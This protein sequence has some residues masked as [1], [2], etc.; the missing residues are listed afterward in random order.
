MAHGFAITWSHIII[1]HTVIF[2]H[3]NVTAKIFVTVVYSF[4][5]SWVKVPSRVIVHVL[6]IRCYNGSPRDRALVLS[7]AYFSANFQPF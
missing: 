4:E 7:I 1:I 3:F 2:V 5:V 6:Y